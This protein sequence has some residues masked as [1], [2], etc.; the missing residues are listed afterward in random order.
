[1]Q[2]QIF[3]FL[4]CFRSELKSA[5]VFVEIYPKLT[6]SNDTEKKP[7]RRTQRYLS[8]KSLKTPTYTDLQALFSTTRGSLAF[9]S[10]VS[11]SAF[12]C[13]FISIVTS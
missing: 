10:C 6:F 12:L 4:L 5:R 13:I 11:I 7:P 1:M 9:A 3:V 2:P 8:N